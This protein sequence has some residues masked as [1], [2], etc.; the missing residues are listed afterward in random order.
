[1]KWFVCGE[2]YRVNL[3]LLGGGGAGVTGGGWVNILIGIALFAL[4][5]LWFSVRY[6]RWVAVWR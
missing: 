4:I 6:R 3:R 1:M 5:C 2:R